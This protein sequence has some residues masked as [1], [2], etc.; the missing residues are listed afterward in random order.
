MK[1][2]LFYAVMAFILAGFGLNIWKYTKTSAPVPDLEAMRRVN[3]PDKSKRSFSMD[4]YEVTNGRFWRFNEKHEYDKG[5][6]DFPVVGVTWGE[7]AAYAKWAGKRL[8]TAA[9]W[10]FARKAR[11]N[12]FTAW[13]AIEQTSEFIDEDTTMLFRVGK[14]WRDRTPLGMVNMASNAWEWTA[15]TLRLENGALAAIVKG[16]F[17][18]KN[19]EL[20]FA[21]PE[22]ADT[23]LVEA[24]SPMVGFRCV[25]DR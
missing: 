8:P 23:V 18:L 12:E 15:D 20:V 7:A 4:K 5:K 24:R 11:K 22:D 1:A 3:Y 25:R 19:G 6:E 13:D 17:T 21:R 16:G 10:E 9:E 2:S 14:F